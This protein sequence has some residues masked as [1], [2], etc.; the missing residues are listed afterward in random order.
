[1]RHSKTARAAALLAAVALMGPTGCASWF[2]R[3][4]M[5]KVRQIAPQASADIREQLAPSDYE[6]AAGAI[7]RRDYGRALEYLQSAKARK[8]QD[9]RVLNAFG[10]V[11]DKLG[12]F[13]LSAR[14]YA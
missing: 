5:V 10:V 8:P 3:P 7:E 13:D 12:R 14:Y 2:H 4:Q 9:V 11:Y 1:M 6:R